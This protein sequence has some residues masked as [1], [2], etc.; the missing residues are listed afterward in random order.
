MKKVLFASTALV[1]LSLT[2]VAQASDPIKLGLG[3]YSKWV[4]AYADNDVTGSKFQ[5]V[6]IKG[7]N[8]VH[9][10]GS[11][12]L[13][14]GIKISV[15]MELEAGGNTDQTTDVIDESYVTVS[16]G[17]GTIIAGTR[18]NGAY[19]LHVTAPDAG[20]FSL[21]SELGI[22]GGTYLAKN[23][24]A[25]PTTTGIDVP[26]TTNKPET[27]TYVAPSF[28][29]FT[30]GASYVPNW[31]EDNRG[32]T[33]DD[34]IGVSDLVG[35]AG[36]YS[37]TFSAVT[38]KASVGYVVAADTAATIN[39]HDQLSLGAQLGYAGFSV[40][41]GYR[42]MWT[43]NSNGTMT[44]DLTATTWTV[45][46]MYAQ[47]PF[48]VSFNYF[49]SSAKGGDSIESYFVSGKYNLGAGVDLIGM[50]GY[51]DFD[52]GNGAARDTNYNDGW[53]VTS[54]IALAF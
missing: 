24:N 37:G 3:G 30:L 21:D 46:A 52:E 40:G 16:G 39:S 26:N 7:T 38:L 19:L 25:A 49:D 28:A 13:D 20:G 53:V 34:L 10:K 1:A 2:G 42:K 11:T 31:S 33:A 51:G 47:G 41:G 50:I 45:G 9:F 6:D 8:E 14:N 23:S 17:F 15:Q 32:A 36:M 12:T 22:N 29:G 5:D 18:W 44:T 43:E 27:L 54:G 4:V 48:A 35:F